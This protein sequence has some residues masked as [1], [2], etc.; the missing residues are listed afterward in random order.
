L[1][2]VRSAV[3]SGGVELAGV[4]VEVDVPAGFVDE[5]VVVAAE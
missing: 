5:G 4:V 2:F 1:Y 3:G